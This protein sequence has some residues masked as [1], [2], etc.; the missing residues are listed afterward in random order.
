[1]EVSDTHYVNYHKHSRAWTCCRRAG[2]PG[3]YAVCSRHPND[4]LLSQKS[5]AD[6]RPNRLIMP[7]PSST[8]CS[9]TGNS[10]QVPHLSWS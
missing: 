5:V 6:T 2:V 1:M 9:L 8:A 3:W 10:S 7:P 4:A